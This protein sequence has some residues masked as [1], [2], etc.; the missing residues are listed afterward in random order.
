MDKRELLNDFKNWLQS[1][2]TEELVN[3]LVDY[4][5]NVT[6]LNESEFGGVKCEVASFR[7]V[8]TARVIDSVSIS[9][10]ELNKDRR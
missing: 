7:F 8:S 5:V 1:M 9:I 2:A 3:S 10:Q 4:G 6:E